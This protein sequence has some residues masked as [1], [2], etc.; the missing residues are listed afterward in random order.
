M[1]PSPRDI[2]GSIHGGAVLDVATG[3]GGFIPFLAEGLAD[4]QRI[5]GIDHDSGKVAA[6]AEAT[7]E[8]PRVQ[9]EERDALEIGLPDGAFDTVAVSNSLHH[10]TDPEQ[11]LREMRRVLRPGGSFIVFEMYRDGQEAPQQT[12]VELHHWWGAVDTRRGIV[13]RPTYSRAELIGLLEPV[14]LTDLR[15]TDVASPEDD[16]LDP[17]S[18]AE[19]DAVIE[20]YLAWADGDPALVVRGHAAPRPPPCG[21]DPGRDLAGHRG[22]QAGGRIASAIHR[23]GRCRR[24]SAG[25]PVRP[26][27]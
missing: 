4:Y 2:L 18:L 15:L 26:D 21:G 14:G 9:F 19:M 27:A 12:H 23:D 7:A 24:A 11:V 22:P 16:P 5:L 20:R 13:H 17:E 10:F 25:S 8:I 6:F 3:G 1:I